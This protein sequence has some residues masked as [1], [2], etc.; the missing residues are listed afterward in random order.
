MQSRFY[1]FDLS[2]GIVV[3]LYFV[4]LEMHL[5]IINNI[6]HHN[7]HCEILDILISIA[8]NYKCYNLQTAMQNNAGIKR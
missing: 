5:S 8:E 4:T 6:K 2:L 7:L 1:R 3:I